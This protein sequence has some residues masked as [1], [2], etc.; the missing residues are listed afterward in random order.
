MSIPTKI[1]NSILNGYKYEATAD[2]LPVN[3]IVCVQL[4]I[5]AFKQSISRSNLV[6]SGEHMK[7][8]FPHAE[9]KGNWFVLKK[10]N[11]NIALT[12]FHSFLNFCIKCFIYDGSNPKT[13]RRSNAMHKCQFCNFF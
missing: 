8:G 9:I 1:L 12:G 11:I 2:K 7:Y 3:G 4:H 10:E 13:K 6:G 5:T